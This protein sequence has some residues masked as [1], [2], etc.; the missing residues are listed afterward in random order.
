MSAYGIY[1][2]A[3]AAVVLP[4]SYLM[5]GSRFR[6]RTMTLASRIACPVDPACLPVGFLC[7]SNSNMEI[8]R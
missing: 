1:N 7:D 3:L 6:R 5:A 4:L 8:S 2:L